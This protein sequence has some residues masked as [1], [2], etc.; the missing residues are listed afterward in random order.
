MVLCLLPILVVEPDVRIAMFQADTFSD[1][2]D[3][4]LDPMLCHSSIGKM[5]RRSVRIQ[6]FFPIHPSIIF[7][8]TVLT[9][10]AMMAQ[11]KR[12]KNKL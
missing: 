4:F 9:S 2:L 5:P 6:E 11:E 1:G 8:H 3:V 10:V 12:N 7:S